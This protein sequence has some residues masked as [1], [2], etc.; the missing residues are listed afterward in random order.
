MPNPAPT[1]ASPKSRRGL[2]SAEGAKHGW[3]PVRRAA[4][5]EAIRRWK[6]WA[7]STG[8]KTAAG[9]ARAAQNAAKPHTRHIREAEQLFKQAMAAQ[10]RYL[11]EIKDYTALMKIFAPNELLRKRR[12]KLL[13]EGKK[14]TYRLQ[15]AF[16][17]LELVN[18]FAAPPP[19]LAPTPSLR[20]GG[21]DAA[22][23]LAAGWMDSAVP[24]NDN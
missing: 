14:V 9:K 10:A 16:I 5:A 12:R 15:A 4:Q 23:H 2:R 18:K 6:P 13:R 19:L 17:L 20:G 8:P 11:R 24:R 21:A 22:I 3:S 7:K 1:A